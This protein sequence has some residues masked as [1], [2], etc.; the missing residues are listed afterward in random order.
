MHRW[1][2][3]HLGFICVSERSGECQRVVLEIESSADNNLLI[4][5]IYL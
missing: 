5:I 3:A 4:K 2:W 1:H